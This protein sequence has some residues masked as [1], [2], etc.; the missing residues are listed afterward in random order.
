MIGSTQIEKKWV[1]VEI[2]EVYSNTNRHPFQT[3]DNISNVKKLLQKYGWL[4][5]LDR[6]WCETKPKMV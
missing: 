4:V 1:E 5:F 2:L 6:S 3:S